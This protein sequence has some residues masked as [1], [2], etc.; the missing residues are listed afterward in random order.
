MG[1]VFL[2]FFAELIDDDPKIFS[3]FAVF[4]A[5]D[6]L[7]QAAMGDGLALLGDELF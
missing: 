4:W 2:D 5:P 1:R 6:G 7:Q 3:F